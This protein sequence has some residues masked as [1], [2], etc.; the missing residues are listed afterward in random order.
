M[1]WPRPVPPYSYRGTAP[2]CSE[3]A[4]TLIR[5]QNVSDVQSVQFDA[6][7]A[8]DHQRVAKLLMDRFGRLDILINNA[9]IALKE[10]P[11]G[12]SG[13]FNTTSVVSE[14]VLRE[15]FDT[16]FFAIVALTQTLLPLLRRSPAGRVVN[17]SSSLAS[18]TLHSDPSSTI[19]RAK[20]FA[21][22]ASKT[23]LNAFTGAYSSRTL[24]RQR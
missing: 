21:Y 4:I 9:G 3:A 10:V 8:A 22:A 5:Q 19:Y 15:T 2:N 23:A 11:S 14:E 16:N 6:I 20:P 24:P 17:V 1:N 13:G 18:L 7:N 12:S